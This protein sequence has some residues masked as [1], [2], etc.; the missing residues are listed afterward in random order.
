MTRKH[1]EIARS[2]TVCRAAFEKDVMTEEM[3]GFE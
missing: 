3:P 2:A 1:K